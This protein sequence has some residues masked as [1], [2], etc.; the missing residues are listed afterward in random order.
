MSKASESLDF[1]L[2]E[3]GRSYSVTVRE[4][5]KSLTE[6]I[7]PQ[8]HGGLPV[9]AL[10]EW[11]FYVCAE[12]ERVVLP[13]SISR[14]GRGAFGGCVKLSEM[15]I[16]ESVEGIEN[17]T[18]WGCEGLKRVSLPQSLKSIGCRAFSWCR[19]LKRI[20][21]PKTLGFVGEDAFEGCTALARVCFEGTQ[22]EYA[23]MLAGQN[24]IAEGNA[25]LTGAKWEYES[26]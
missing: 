8:E 13:A 20:S 2:N 10:G 7:V 15:D 9:T 6:V 19:R 14:I 17:D 26:K 25:C 4:S 22:Y 3:D 11:A 5:C 12:L 16:P 24:R 23:Q 18:F 1:V 21:L